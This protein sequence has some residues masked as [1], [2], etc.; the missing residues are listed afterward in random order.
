MHR[1]VWQ[2]ALIMFACQC[3]SYGL[4]LWIPQI[5]KG[6]SGFSNFA[7]AMI[8]SIPYIGAAIGMI[9]IGISSD[10][11]GERFLHIA[12]PCFIGAI[13]FA[14]S[15]LMQSPLPGLIALTVAAIGDLGSRGP[16]WSLPGR[17]LTSS[18]SAG[19]IALI[20]TVGAIGGFVGPYA[21]GLVKQSTGSFTGG[22]FLLA[23][24]L[25][26][27][28]LGTLA[29]RSSPTLVARRTPAAAS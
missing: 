26:A 12:V 5:V 27:A 15:A 19:G 10:R 4:T 29:L 11:T 16:F 21:V 24:L 9:V 17:F 6:L 28:A 2:L 25:F 20:N 22:L 1:T 23:G 7:V 14:A 13:G 18:A 8:S 3:G